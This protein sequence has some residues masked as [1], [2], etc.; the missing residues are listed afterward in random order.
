MVTPEPLSES[1][2][3]G[4][5]KCGFELQALYEWIKTIAIYKKNFIIYLNA[6]K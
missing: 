6:E 4:G 2:F 3:Q 1:P 5:N